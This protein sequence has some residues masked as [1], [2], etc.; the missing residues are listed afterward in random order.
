MSAQRLSKKLAHLFIVINKENYSWKKKVVALITS[1][2]NLTIPIRF[3]N[4]T[5]FVDFAIQTACCN[6][7]G[8]LPEKRSFERLLYSPFL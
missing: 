1:T 5:D 7:S 4:A 8:K 6:E 2:G 3:Y